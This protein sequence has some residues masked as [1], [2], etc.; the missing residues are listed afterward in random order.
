MLAMDEDLSRFENLNGGG[1][2]VGALWNR[3]RR[4]KSSARA[5]DLMNRSPSAD[6]EEDGNT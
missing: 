4:L 3:R 1:S 6:G 5:L 2:P